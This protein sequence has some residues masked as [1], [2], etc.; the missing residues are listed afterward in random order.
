MQLL[1]DLI[2][3]IGVRTFMLIVNLVAAVVG[4]GATKGWEHCEINVKKTPIGG[5]S[6]GKQVHVW[7]G[8]LEVDRGKDTI[9]I[10]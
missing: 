3:Y 9:R 1:F 5:H 7:W 4:K 6:T 8:L 10:L 2:S